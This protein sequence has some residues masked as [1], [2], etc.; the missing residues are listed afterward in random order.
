M[1]NIVIY[2][3][4]SILGIAGLYTLYISSGLLFDLFG[5]R[6]ETETYIQA[7]SI[8]NFIC[9]FLY[10]FSSYLFFRKSKLSTS[11]L[12]IATIIMFI[13]YIGMLFHIQAQRPYGVRII[14]EML[15]RTSGTMLY[16]ATAWYIFTRVRLVLPS[17]YTYKDM[18]NR[19]KKIKMEKLRDMPGSR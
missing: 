13:G 7:T 12:F 8:S 17:G 10:L 4:G 6:H 15:I 9:S 1:K 14:A 5:V 3:L 19:A 2:I 11:V 18:K 16:A